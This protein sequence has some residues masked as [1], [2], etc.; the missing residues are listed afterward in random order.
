MAEHGATG[1]RSLARFLAESGLDAELVRPG[2]S[3]P[4]VERA[5]AALGVG[6][7][8]IVKS[9]VF[10]HK[11]DPSRVCLAIVPGDSRVERTQVAAVLGL[12]RLKLA[13]PA[14]VLAAVGF[15]VGGV[16]PVG[17]RTRLPVVLD[18]VVLEQELV[19][20]GGGDEESMLRIRPQD[21]VRSTGATVASVT[22]LEDEVE[23]SE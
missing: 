20:G 5:A 10:Q 21:I 9:V 1:T 2:A 18:P 19:Y 15:P 16:P 3:M 11:K 22:T 23:G 13:S 7:R 14:V 4:T 8:Q 17:H 6:P 12:G